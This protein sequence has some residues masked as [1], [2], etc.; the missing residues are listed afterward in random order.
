MS[1]ADLSILT[2]ALAEIS[3]P[4]AQSVC[5]IQTTAFDRCDL[6]EVHL[7]PSGPIACLDAAYSDASASAACILFSTWRAGTPL[8][9]LTSRRGAPAAYEPGS[10][11]KRELPLLLSVLEKV[12][13][14]PA[15]IIIDGYVWLDAH[16]RPGLGAILHETLTKKVPV[17]GVAKTVFGDALS[18]CIPVVRGVSR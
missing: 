4:G 1:G 10:F 16:H 9:T 11:Y 15:V 18:W 12:Q 3:G 6:E 2:P 5:P 14:L 8:C 17:V 13:R 7:Q